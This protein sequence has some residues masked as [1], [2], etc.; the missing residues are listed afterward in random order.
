MTKRFNIPDL[1]ITAILTIPASGVTTASSKGDFTT[2]SSDN[3]LVSF[4]STYMGRLLA[5]LVAI[6]FFIC[7]GC[8]YDGQRTASIPQKTAQTSADYIS[9]DQ[10]EAQYGIR[11]MLIGVSANGGIVDFRYKVSDPVKAA[12]VLQDST[13]TAVLTAVDSG[14]SLTPTNM[15]RHHGQMAG[16]RGAVPFTFYPNVRNAV[17]HGTLVSVAFGKIKVEPIAAQ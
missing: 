17:K 13:N 2:I 11:I 6:A 12:T 14:L 9:N 15:G 7:G 4:L 10:L 5:A 8:N 1:G 3:T 16:K